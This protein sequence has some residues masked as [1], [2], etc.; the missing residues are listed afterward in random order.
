VQDSYTRWLWTRQGENGESGTS[1]RAWATRE[2]AIADA[3]ERFPDDHLFAD[4]KS[5]GAAE[6]PP[7][8]VLDSLTEAD[9]I[10]LTH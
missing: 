10:G 5:D 1:P 6:A 3:T 8:P 7:M 4:G 2:E 9:T